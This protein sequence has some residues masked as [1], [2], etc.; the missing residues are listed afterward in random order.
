MSGPELYHPRRYY[1]G[2]ILEHFDDLPGLFRHLKLQ[3][4]R[5]Q[6]ARQLAREAGDDFIVLGASD[7]CNPLCPAKIVVREE[8]D[9]TLTLCA[10]PEA[11]AADTREDALLQ[12]LLMRLDPT[13][14]SPLPRWYLIGAVAED[15]G[16]VLQ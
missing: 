8:T 5:Y 12:A 13:N 1:A 3:P 6:A 15:V 7:S 4:E 2:F 10:A 11:T 9:G 16:V 14:P